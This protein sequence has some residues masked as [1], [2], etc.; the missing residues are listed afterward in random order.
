MTF[1]IGSGAHQ[2][3]GSPPVDQGG[4]LGGPTG[5]ED[6]PAGRPEVERTGSRHPCGFRPDED[7]PAAVLGANGVKVTDDL[8]LA[9]MA[10]TVS[11]QTA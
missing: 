11:R 9:I 7:H 10:A 6:D 1:R 4:E 5:S 3:T 2:R 8:G